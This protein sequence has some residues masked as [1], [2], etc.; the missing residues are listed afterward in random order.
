MTTVYLI[1]HAEAEG[2][3]Y[4]RC[5]GQ[6]DSLLTGKGEQQAK[7]LAKRFEAIPLDA[8]FASDLYR[9]RQTAQAIADVKGMTV[10]I[11]PALREINMGEW[12]DRTWA[13]LPLVYP[14]HAKLWREAPWKCL[15]PGGESIMAAGNRV[16]D[17][18]V[19]LVNANK[20][21]AI[22]VVSH[23]TAI[24]GI[25][26]IAMGL[27]AESMMEIGWGDNTCVAKINFLGDG[28]VVV[29]YANDTTHIPEELS[30]FASLKWKNTDE[31]PTSAQMWFKPVDVEKESDTLLHFARQLYESAYGDASL[32]DSDKFIGETLE[33]AKKNPRAV[34]FGM[35]DDLP[36]A[37]VRMN[38]LDN[39]APDT[40]MVGSFCIEEKYRGFGF[41]PQIL[42]QAISVY[43]QMGKGYLAAFVAEKN[44]R[45]QKFYRNYGFEQIGEHKNELGN[46][47]IMRKNIMV[48]RNG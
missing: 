11:K 9:A 1:R 42:G 25:L 18:L 19:R 13:E 48:K 10:T 8:I 31:A 5:H 45:A 40:G 26:C 2:N 35:L 23:G 6:Y 39:S 17:E 15:V 36:G 41:A 46:H 4:R 14:E 28:S 21:K 22:A 7:L 33:M 30:T 38:V 20:D 34:T 3:V 27:P 24:R 37:L 44:L 47:L 29:E 16:Y 32:L 12:E 43:R